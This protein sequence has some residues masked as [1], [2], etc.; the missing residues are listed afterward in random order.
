MN[1]DRLIRRAK[2]T[3]KDDQNTTGIDAEAITSMV[4]AGKANPFLSGSREHIAFAWT[5]ELARH[6]ASDQPTE[7]TA[8]ARRILPQAVKRRRGARPS[9]GTTTTQATTGTPPIP[10][11]RPE[12][13]TDDAIPTKVPPK[14]TTKPVPPKVPTVEIWNQDQLFPV[15]REFADEID[16]AE[17]SNNEW[18]KVSPTDALGRY[19]L[20]WR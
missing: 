7:L 6:A 2:R 10:A 11:A 8:R 4:T 20:R 18:D 15:S 1:Q 16:R 5:E 13:P 3:A 12:Q 19:Q 9:V 14:P 17:N